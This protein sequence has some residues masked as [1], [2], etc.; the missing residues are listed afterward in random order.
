MAGL[1]V[2]AIY[3]QARLQV[4]DRYKTLEKAESTHRF[5]MDKQEPAKRGM[6]LSAD[7]KPLA[8]DDDT[9]SL[10]VQFEDVPNSDAFF[11]EL[12]AATG[13]PASEFSQLS[14]TGITSKTWPQGMTAAQQKSVQAVKTKWR[15]NGVS[16]APSG[17]RSY[18]LGSAASC[19]VGIS[20]QHSKLGLEKS[21]NKDLQGKDGHTVGLV[22]RGGSFLPMRLSK[23]ST[24][25]ENGKDVELTIDSELQTIATSAIKQA[26][27]SNKAERGVAILYV[28]GTGDILAMANWPSFDPTGRD[29]PAGTVVSDFN[30]CTMSQLEPGS[31]FKVL[32]LAKALDMD[33]IDEHWTGYCP[34]TKEVSGHILHCAKHEVHRQVDI[35]KAI[36]E[37]CN[38]SAATWALK[39]GPTEYRKYLRQLEVLKEPGLGL[40]HEKPG[41]FD[42]NDSAEVLQTALLGFGQAIGVT[43]I[44][45]ASAF[46]MIGN[47]GIRM[48]PRL[49]RRVGNMSRPPISAGLMI[50]PETADK[51]MRCM[52]A[53]VETD[54]G[55]GKSLRIPGYRLAGKTGTAE[56]RGGGRSGY[57]SNFVGFIPAQDPKVMILVMVDN[58]TNGAYFGAQVAG[59]VFS[60]LA[61]AAIRRLGIPPTES[62][63][64]PADTVPAAPS[65]KKSDRSEKTHKSDGPDN[66]ARPRAKKTKQGRAKRQ[67]V[68]EYQDN[69]D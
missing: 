40:P 44:R 6:I 24:P 13:I 57:V 17:Q 19:I 4:V 47:H 22:D 59:P 50:K 46:A 26:V 32:T 55:T 31:M 35:T 25:K 64:A 66:A 33:A 38:V 49:I 51:V 14:A 9:Y 23:D 58:P 29:T 3:S 43:P 10:V 65:L 69:R 11:V 18:P 16:I 67:V 15:A 62:A 68:A 5:T 39:I 37:S 45:A 21:F 63:L 61:R 8:Q 12:S 42:W 54:A 36:A 28:P 41:A 1:F 7:G 48:E 34:G 52:E 2:L 56:R 60:T 20:S 30:A 27:E 53:V